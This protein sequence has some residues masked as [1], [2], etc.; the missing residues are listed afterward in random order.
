MLFHK[1]EDDIYLCDNDEWV[2]IVAQKLNV[3]DKIYAPPHKPLQICFKPMYLRGKNYFYIFIHFNNDIDGGL[4][5]IKAIMNDINIE[6][7]S[8]KI[9]NMLDSFNID[10][11]EFRKLLQ[12]MEMN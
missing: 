1:V 5:C 8:H 2:K 6:R 10:G 3:L 9:S 11:N 4:T 12:S 7:V